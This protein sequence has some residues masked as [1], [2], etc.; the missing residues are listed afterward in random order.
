M[1]RTAFIALLI[2]VFALSVTAQSLNRKSVER[3]IAP[4]ISF[5][6]VQNAPGIYDGTNDRCWGNTFVLYGTGEWFSAHVTIAMDYVSGIPDPKIGN[7]IVIG[8]WTMAFFKDNIYYGTLYG[9]VTQGTIT[10]FQNP[11]TGVIENR[12]TN[13][14]L[15]IVGEMGTPEKLWEDPVYIDYRANTVLATRSVTSAMIDIDR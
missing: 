15:L 4:G 2:S 13:A 6:G 8:T 5:T 7:T 12:H 14:K 3:M 11:K 9:Y 10:W 1:R